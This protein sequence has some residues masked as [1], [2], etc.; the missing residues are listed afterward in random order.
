MTR[1]LIFTVDLDRDVNFPMEGSVAAGSIDRGE[2]TSPRFSSADKGLDILLDVLDDVG[3]KAT[4]F[5]EGRTA[6]VLD[7]SRISGHCIG[8][9]GYDHE[10]LTG[11]STG[12][13]FDDDSLDGILRRG[14]DAVSDNVSRPV[15]FRAPYMSCDDRVLRSVSDLGIRHDSSVYSFNGAQPY[16]VGFGITEHPVPK[17]RDVNGKTIAAYLW[18]MHEGK[19]LPEDYIHMASEVG[20]GDHIIATHTWHMVE[21]REGG[22]LDDRGISLNA[23]MVHEVLSGILDLGFRPEILVH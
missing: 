20:E 23:S 11:S 9:H 15:C 19:R 6:E 18:P 22:P 14:F 5:V 7:C 4:F 12:V 3:M 1:K 21:R 16:T 10:D 2:G 8:F 13:V 17:G